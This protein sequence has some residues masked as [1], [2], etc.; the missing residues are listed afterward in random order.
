MRPS[1]IPVFL[2]LIGAGCGA[3]ALFPPRWAPQPFQGV[4][5]GMAM[6]FV[7][8]TSTAV[9]ARSELGAIPPLFGPRGMAPVIFVRSLGFLAILV[10]ISYVYFEQR[11]F[12]DVTWPVLIL[13]A[14]SLSEG[15]LRSRRRVPV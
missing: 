4:L 12:Y 2:I 8:V 13:A 5:A 10:G 15:L 7:A 14:W 9:R 6:Y 11:S 1:W 3:F